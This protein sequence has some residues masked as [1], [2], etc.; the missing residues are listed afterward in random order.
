M[1]FQALLN[2]VTVNLA[3]LLAFPAMAQELAP[4]GASACSGC[5][6]PLIRPGAAL[7]P[8]SALPP[9]AVAEA[10][11]AFKSGARDSTVMG[12]IAK[13]FSDGEIEAIANYLGKKP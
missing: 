8:V 1:A 3:M 2:L 9:Q 10:M 6:A 11:R 7:P 13:G 12:R 5:H 4:P